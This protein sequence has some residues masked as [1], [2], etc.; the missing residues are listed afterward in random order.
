MTITIKDI[1]E[2]AGVS[3]STVSKAMRNSPLVQ[4]KTKLKILNIAKELGYQPNAAARRLV[5]KKSWVIGVVWPSV[6]RET[7]SALITKINDELEKH[8]YTTLLSINRIESAIETFNRFQVDAI[9]VFNERDN[10]IVRTASFNSSVPIV[11]YGTAGSTLPTTIDANRKQAIKLAVQYLVHLGHKSI[12]YIGRLPVKDPLQEDKIEAFI[13]ELKK[14]GLPL[15]KESIIPI[16]SMETHEGYLSARKL[17]QSNNT[18]SAI[19]SG[20]YDL[21]RGIMKAASEAKLSIPKD[22]SIISY[23]NIPQMED[24]DVPVTSVGVAI[25]TLAEKTIQALLEVIEDRGLESGKSIYL[26][27]EL[28]VRASVAEIH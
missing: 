24:F 3:F 11:N 8:S 20:S 14:C 13:D 25:T 21:T 23:D 5:S 16:N 18:P 19:I 4:E 10:N 9:L 26:Q 6:E 28:I 22:L 15:V 12:S 2:K 17:I 27:P 1:A 7:L